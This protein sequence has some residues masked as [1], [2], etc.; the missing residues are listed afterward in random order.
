MT[1]EIMYQGHYF[2]GQRNYHFR[3]REKGNCAQ[4]RKRRHSWHPALVE[5]QERLPG[6]AGPAVEARLRGTKV[7]SAWESHITCGTPWF[8]H[9]IILYQKGWDPQQL[10]GSH[11]RW[12]SAGGVAILARGLGSVLAMCVISWSLVRIHVPVAATGNVPSIPRQRDPNTP[13]S[14]CSPTSRL[15]LQHWR[16][17]DCMAR[18]VC[19]ALSLQGSQ[20]SGQSCTAHSPEQ[21]AKPLADNLTR[22][23]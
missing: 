4:A 2:P 1:F 11:E 5:G 15:I 14:W 10:Q 13:S 9:E 7:L 17:G 18:N 19:P 22:D 23:F 12:C 20:G 6:W 3:W 8:G 21:T 16:D